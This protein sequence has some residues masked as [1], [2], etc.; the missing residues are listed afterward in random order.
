VP[1]RLFSAGSG[2]YDPKTGGSGSGT[3][4]FSVNFRLFRFADVVGRFLLVPLKG[5][6]DFNA[7]SVVL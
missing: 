4:F 2:F 7:F 5:W 1:V 6:S 3:G